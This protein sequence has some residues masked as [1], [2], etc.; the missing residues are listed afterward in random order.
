MYIHNAL[1]S[2]HVGGKDH[3][4]FLSIIS[5]S[6]NSFFFLYMIHD[7]YVRNQPMATEP[8]NYIQAM[9]DKTSIGL[10]KR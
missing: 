1:K 6:V 9:P 10:K 8:V 5:A 4:Q 3:D 2:T 7:T